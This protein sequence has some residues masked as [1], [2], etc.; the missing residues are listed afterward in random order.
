MDLGG[1]VEHEVIV[2]L[3]AV[4]NVVAVARNVVSGVAED[5]SVVSRMDD[6]AAE[7]GVHD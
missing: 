2:L 4:F 6:I 3:D 7:H 1:Q 5:A